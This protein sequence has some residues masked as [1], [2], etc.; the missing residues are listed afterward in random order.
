MI[1]F[2]L[3][4]FADDMAWKNYYNK[5]RY[6]PK[7]SALPRY[8]GPAKL[9]SID[10]KSAIIG[11]SFNIRQHLKD[12][13]FAWNE[14]K[15]DAKQVV[16]APEVINGAQIFNGIVTQDVISKLQ[17]MGVD[18][19]TPNLLLTIKTNQD[20]VQPQ[21]EPQANP[22]I[23]QG[24][25]PTPQDRDVVE[26]LK[27]AKTYQDT[28]EAVEKSIT[29]LIEMIK[30]PARQEE[31]KERIL[32][33]ARF[34]S[35]M[36][37]YSLFNKILILSQHPD[38]EYVGGAKTFWANVGRN[39]NSNA[40]PI[41]I[42][43]PQFRY[44]YL[45]AEKKKAILT[46]MKG[47]SSTEIRKAIEQVTPKRLIGFKPVFVYDVKDTQ[48][49]PNWRDPKTG[50]PALDI[51]E[52]HKWTMP[53]KNEDQYIDAL[54]S[55]AIGAIQ[56][57]GIKIHFQDMKGGVGGVSAGGNIIIPK[58]YK[59]VALF[60]SLVHEWAHEI[61]LKEV[62]VQMTQG[63]LGKRTHDEYSLDEVD[64]E[65]TAFVVMKAFNIDGGEQAAAN[66]LTGW[67][68]GDPQKIRIR[69]QQ[70]DKAVKE[71]VLAIR[72]HIKI[73]ESEQSNVPIQ[74]GNPSQNN[75]VSKL[76]SIEYFNLLK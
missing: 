22:S 62:R 69:Q 24:N 55:A 56:S 1:Y 5:G 3:F 28:T 29:N 76:S 25:I 42:L 70:I 72:N 44:G 75:D 20:N 9:V 35:Q 31:A 19:S 36:W 68:K 11:N 14:I 59:G 15:I 74:Q 7:P 13:G 48:I 38:A 6:P 39:V 60:N 21:N 54:S 52:H 45:D 17:Q 49:D 50:Q 41:T 53:S 63:K 10:G 37:N 40:M 23:Q 26:R 2:D 32:R 61:L 71:I 65:G 34:T 12:L 4:K 18:V 30:D 33:Y 43:A 64:A 16:G 8:Y 46:K 27:Q 66:Y 73:N 57:N 51:L 47:H 58:D 67:M